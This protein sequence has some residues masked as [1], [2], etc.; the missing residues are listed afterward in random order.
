MPAPGPAAL[1]R[2]VVIN[3]G[4]AIPAPWI[5]A[6]V[7]TVDAAGLA[8]PKAV[9]QRLHEAWAAREPIVIELAVDP[10]QFREPQSID[11]EPW[12]LAVDAEPFFDRLHFLVWANT[13]DGRSG[14]LIW[15]WG[16][17][18]ARLDEDAADTPVGPADITLPDGSP[19]WI[20]G[21]PRR[22]WSADDVSGASVVH[23]ETV[24]L[25]SLAVS[26]PP[27][28][29]TAD[30]ADD[31]RAAVAHGSGPARV[32]APAGS[33]KTRVL[34]ERLRHLAVDR[35]YESRGLLAVAYNKQAQLEM[36]SR[37]TAFRPRVRTL[38]SLGL[39]VLAQ[40]R[41][42]SPP[43]M[44]ERDVRRLVEQLMPG[45]RQRRSNTDPIGPYV[46]ALS[47]IRL[48]L[49]DPDDVEASRD[50]VPGIAEMF[51]PFRAKLTERGGV[52]FDEQIYSAIEL[53]LRD[54]PFR[55]QMQQQCRHLLVDEFQDLTPA[56]V[57]LIRLLSLPTLDVFAAGDDDQ[58][59]YGHAGADPA[60]LI[61][62]AAL[63][64][65]AVEHPLTV[66]YRCAVEIVDGAR[67]L[68]GYNRRRVPK[69]IHAG[70]GT[71][72]AAGTLR[73]ISHGPDD[74]AEATVAA[75]QEWLAEPGV[76][77]GSIAVLARVNSLLLAPH[78]ALH[79]AGIP[80]SSVLSPEV[81]QRTGMRAALAYLRIAASPK[82]IDP[83]DVI[84]I[85]R[86]P[87]RGLPQWFPDRLQRRGSWTVAQ[88]RG[89]ADQ[90]PEKDGVKVH[91]LADDL[92]VVVAAGRGGTT[93]T[94]LEA[95]RDDVGLG[96][97]M[98]L[99]DRTG[100]GQ[101][102]SH[103]DDLEGLLGVADLHP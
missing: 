35:G 95:V 64:P 92:D 30:L 75:L 88:I 71:D 72:G 41:G 58:V 17:K 61:E 91:R 67:H 49:A 9:V 66:N 23:A 80:L 39:W 65:G 68:L 85:L 29:P 15:W 16:R 98:S 6:P 62:Y 83:D 87:T 7:V 18:A 96:S 4:G 13:Y 32:I 20:D 48:G 21:G 26:P 70:P 78:V 97:A 101:G 54:G 77:P 79:E 69:E 53:L 11:A 73:V 51:R 90:V 34:T 40:H 45:K 59:L 3:A 5:A 63:F 14:E 27:V 36:E 31:Q 84:E 2:A 33:G 8:D 89:I 37:T 12:Q 50:D 47:L 86:R 82:Q 60:F 42:S 44:E 57:L 76:E 19:A 1:G 94:V 38:N 22:P 74:G 24:E 46:E 99:L 43:V 81:L 25:G 102:S 10:G 56:H 55:R 93:R 103:L 100:G 28:E 52:D